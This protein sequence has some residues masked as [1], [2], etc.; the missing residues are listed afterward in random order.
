M[1]IKECGRMI[2]EIETIEKELDE[3]IQQKKDTQRLVIKPLLNQINNIE[4]K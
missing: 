1:S 3:L 4:V 2:K